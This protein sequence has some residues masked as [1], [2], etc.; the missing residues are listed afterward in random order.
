MHHTEECEIP[1]TKK[2][3]LAMAFGKEGA[4]DEKHAVE[5]GL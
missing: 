1:P 5:Y 2:S 4:Y 3:W